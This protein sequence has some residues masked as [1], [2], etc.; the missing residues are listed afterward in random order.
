MKKTIKT[1]V[2]IAAAIATLVSCAKEAPSPIEENEELIEITL[3]AGNPEVQPATGSKTTMVGSTPYWCDG[4][5][6]GVSNGTS[7]NNSFAENSIPEGETAATA[8]FS[9]SSVSGTL[10]AYYPY[11]S[12]GVSSNGAKVDIPVNQSP[13]A[14]SFDGAADIMLSKSFSVSPANTTVENLQFARLGAIVKIVLTDTEDTMEGTQHPTTVS[15]TAASNLVG[16]VYIDMV[17]QTLGEL[18]SGQ[19]TTVTAN[20]TAETKY[21]IN[22]S[23]ATYLIVYPQTLAAGSTL[24]ITASTEDYA[25]EK[26]ISVPAGGIELLPGKVNTLN[27]SLL[28]SHI[29]EDTGAALPFND[30]FSWQTSTGNSEMSFDSSPAIPSAKY[31]AYN[32]I[33]QGSASGV[34]R[35]STS[36]TTGYL[37]TVELDLRSAFYVHINSKYWSDSDAT[38]LYVSVDDGSPEEITLTSSYADYYVNFAAATKKSKVKITTTSNK[39]AY[40]KAFDIISGAYAFP[41]VINVSSSNPMAVANTAG[42]GTITYTVSNPTEAS[43]TAA[44]KPQEPAVTWIT[45]IDYSVPGEV[46][47]NIA[48]QEEDALARSAVIVLS[49]TGADNVEVT[50]NQAAGPSSGGGPTEKEYYKLNTTSTPVGTSNTYDAYTSISCANNLASY[51]TYPSTATWSTTCG[52]KQSNTSFWWGSNSKQSSK[53]NLGNGSVSGASA[54]A[55]ALGV[56]TSDTYYSALICSTAFANISKVVMT[57]TTPGGNAPSNVYLLYTTDDGV[58]YTLAGTQSDGA[59]VTFTI[60]SPVASAKYAIVIKCSGYCQYKDPIITFHTTD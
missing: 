42:S 59:T 49:Y 26:E 12:N 56:N 52:S 40:I 7:T 23:N 24:T 48:A 41:P 45:D 37:T 34:A 39:R 31:S 28:A 32:K 16:R 47:F 33:F 60:A 6:I 35:M 8:T 3:I 20:Y 36:S 43:L 17:N 44:L 4:D 29:T 51:G 5:K 54:I 19:S 2:A 27:I 1:F 53:M 30:N 14:S 25:I 15:M 11:T 58:N 46:S 13:T 21:A 18:Y 9:G 50:V 57:R 22:G 38:K 55:T 10:Y